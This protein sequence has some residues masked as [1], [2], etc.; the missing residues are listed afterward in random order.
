MDATYSPFCRPRDIVLFIGVGGQSQRRWISGLRERFCTDE[1]KECADQRKKK[2]RKKRCFVTLGVKKTLEKHCI[3]PL[4]KQAETRW[5][6]IVVV[7]P[8]GAIA[9]QWGGSKSTHCRKNWGSL[10]H[11]SHVSIHG[12]WSI[13]RWLFWNWTQTIHFS[14]V[15]EVLTAKKMLLTNPGSLYVIIILILVEILSK[16]SAYQTIRQQVLVRVISNIQEIHLDE[17]YSRPGRTFISTHSKEFTTYKT[18]HISRF[19]DNYYFYLHQPSSFCFCSLSLSELSISS[20]TL[21]NTSS[22]VVTEAP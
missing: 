15:L 5:V 10:G 18:S 1:S 2:L 19:D 4:T 21:R 13:Q 16:E 9:T 22:I 7:L 20:P 17:G 11:L 6:C 12:S 14:N 3:P 8:K